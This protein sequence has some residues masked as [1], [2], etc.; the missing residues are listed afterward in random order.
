MIVNVTFM[1]SLCLQGYKVTL[2]V[3][4]LRGGAGRVGK[5]EGIFVYLRCIFISS[6]FLQVTP[7]VDD[8]RS[9]SY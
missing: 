2:S 5:W 6:D 4:S 3:G 7:I 9:P 1:H 8:S